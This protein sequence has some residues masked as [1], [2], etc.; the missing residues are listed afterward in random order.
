MEVVIEKKG[1]MVGWTGVQGRSVVAITGSSR[2]RSVRG[3]VTKE[4]AGWIAPVLQQLADK[5]EARTQLGEL[6]DGF[7]RWKDNQASVMLSVHQ[8]VCGKFIRLEV[9]PALVR[10]RRV[11][12]YIPSGNRG[13]G[14]KAV[15]DSLDNLVNVVSTETAPAMEV[16]GV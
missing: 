3:F 6:A 10:R 16:G 11:C 9:S 12:F 4:C 2:K 7:R 1:F 15:A 5:G 8:N 13:S 14:W